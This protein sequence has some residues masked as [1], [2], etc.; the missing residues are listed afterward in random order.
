MLIQKPAKSKSAAA[1]SAAAAA[2]APAAPATTKVD[3]STQSNYLA[4]R[5]HAL[6]LQLAADFERKVLSGFVELQAKV[7]DEKKGAGCLVLDTRSL[8]VHSVQLVGAGAPTE[9]KV[10]VGVV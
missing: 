2:P 6:H 7:V 3:H 10:C 5:V 1:V 9:L 8:K 4:V